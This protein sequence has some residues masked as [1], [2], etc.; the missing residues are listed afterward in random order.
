MERSGEI[1]RTGRKGEM[2]A[3]AG[4]PS[5]VCL[6]C[7]HGQTWHGARSMPFSVSGVFAEAAEAP[8]R[9]P[10]LPPKIASET[11]VGTAGHPG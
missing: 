8:S 1:G 4:A 2:P 6:R 10:L 5:G 7:H 11:S 3:S 9:L